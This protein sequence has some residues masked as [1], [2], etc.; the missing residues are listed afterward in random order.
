MCFD[1]CLL[2]Q[3]RHL[4][5]WMPVN[6]FFLH[7]VFLWI[8]VRRVLFSHR[9]MLPCRHFILDSS[10]V[11]CS[12]RLRGPSFCKFWRVKKRQ[13]F[14]RLRSKFKLSAR[15]VMCFSK[16]A[17]QTVVPTWWWRLPGTASR[18]WPKLDSDLHIGAD[19]FWPNI[20]S[21]WNAGPSARWWHDYS[22]VK[23]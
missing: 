22:F 7:R 18:R 11:W 14:G 13:N 9:N 3:L 16:M 8:H 17:D 12:C 20:F 1:S 2:S 6:V 23:A 21:I 19:G 5:Q 4:F 15:G 10:R